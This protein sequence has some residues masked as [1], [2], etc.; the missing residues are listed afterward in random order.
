MFASGNWNYR[1][2]PEDATCDDDDD[3]SGGEEEN[4][5]LIDED[6]DIDES[7]DSEDD[8]ADIQLVKR[9]E[10]S[11][12]PKYRQTSNIRHSLGNKL[13]DHSDVVGASP[14]CAAPTTSSFST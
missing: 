10:F 14:V 2:D 1:F 13:V 9:I 12:V 8:I 7:A 11:Q 3:S 6:A 5:V 4:Y